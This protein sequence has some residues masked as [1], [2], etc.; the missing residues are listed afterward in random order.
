M[1]TSN[2]IYSDATSRPRTTLNATVTQACGCTVDF[3]A[4]AE[5]AGPIFL[6]AKILRALIPRKPRYL[7]HCNNHPLH[8]SLEDR[9]RLFRN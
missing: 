5:G 7:I 4:I 9:A 8:V 6:P 3:G 1:V 2:N